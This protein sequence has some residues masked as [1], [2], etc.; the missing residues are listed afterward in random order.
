MG[1]Y[2][3]VLQQWF[4][5]SLQ[6]IFHCWT[7]YIFDRP[8]KFDWVKRREIEEIK[9]LQYKL[10]D[11][12]RSLLFGVLPNKDVLLNLEKGVSKGYLKSIGGICLFGQDRTGSYSP[13]VKKNKNI[14]VGLVVQGNRAIIYLA[15]GGEGRYTV[16]NGL[17]L[18]LFYFIKI[19]LKHL[20]Y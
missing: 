11:K 7:R 16:T 6:I 12:I 2:Y 13:H 17:A 10:S 15:I 4:D 9:R 5:S 14:I 1:I 3:K 20:L 19:S 18:F 8:T